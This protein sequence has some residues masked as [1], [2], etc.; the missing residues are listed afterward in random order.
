MKSIYDIFISYRSEGGFETANL[1][2][3]RLSKAG[4][5][6][7]M[8]CEN[9]R[10]GKFNEQ[11]Y[12]YLDNCK[13]V[14]VIL[15]AGSLDRCS[16]EDDWVRLELARALEQK[17]NIVPLMLR[18]F[19]FPAVLPP[20]IDSIRE[21]EGVEASQQLFNASVERLCKLLLSHRYMTPGK[22]KRILRYAL[23][24]LL[25]AAAVLLFFHMQKQKENE[26]ERQQY[27]QICKEEVSFLGTEFVKLNNILI[28]MEDIHTEWVRFHDKFSHASPEEKK[29]LRQEFTKYVDFKIQRLDTT[30]P[31]W[32]LSPLYENIL[33]KNGIK[34]EDIKSFLSVPHFS[35]ALDY[36]E[37]MRIWA[38]TPETGWP[39]TLNEGIDVLTE[40]NKEMIV[41]SIYGYQEIVIAMPVE[42]RENYLKFRSIITKFPD[43]GLNRT[44]AEFESLENQSIQRCNELVSRY[45]GL[46]GNERKVVEAEQRKLDSLKLVY[47]NTFPSPTQ[48]KIDAMKDTIAIKKERLEESKEKLS[49]AEKKLKDT[50]QRAL[51][52]CTFDKHEEP[53]MMWG[54]ILHLAQ[55]GYRAIPAEQK[56][57]LEYIRLKKQAG[58]DSG[59]VKPIYSL[60]PPKLIF[61]DVTKLLDLYLSYNK[62]KDPGA[63]Q[64]VSVAK[65]Y[66]KLVADGKL[67]PAGILMIGTQNNVPHPVL[68]TGDIIIERKGKKIL[69]TDDYFKLKDDPAPNVVKILRFTSS[70]KMNTITEQM[71]VSQVLV[72]FSN[73][74]EE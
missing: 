21:Y 37:K 70:G 41:G 53:G 67:E 69:R 40:L 9:L 36:Y 74:R 62:A 65:K 47:R 16:N 22:A 48:Q 7:F 20:D 59:K 66:F 6:V 33:T 57:K 38:N 72:G 61:E 13:D 42:V 5:K 30:A 46:V 11:L 45:A 23:A 54:K 15:S 60:L 14:I 34:T 73:L 43:V 10:S 71:P 1:I 55:V 24:P 63:A 56:N 68:K 4:Y 12:Y 8:D 32:Q 2:Y 27:I 52:K 17:K 31:K 25:I 28:D 26:T 51:T 29:R 18:N 44:T 39:G 3:D 50:Y 35:E 19:A 58:K 49:D 64:Y